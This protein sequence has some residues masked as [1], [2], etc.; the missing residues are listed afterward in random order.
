MSHG[1]KDYFWGVAPEKSVF[2][3]LQEAF[4]KTAAKLFS[5]GSNYAIITYT[6]PAGYILNV[7]G[8]VYG[9][10]S[11]GISR[12][13]IEKDDVMQ[14]LGH[15]DVF[16]NILLNQGGEIVLTAGQKLDVNVYSLLDYSA[17]F[18]A[19]VYGFLQQ[20]VV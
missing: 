16:A 9:C 15:F 18:T 11:P 3:E 20:T 2:G 17:W 1:R 6:V 12:W 7:T 14:A 19:Y 10:D 13:D 4:T 8:V 5:A